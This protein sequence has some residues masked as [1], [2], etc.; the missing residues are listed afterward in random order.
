MRRIALRRLA[1]A[2]AISMAPLLSPLAAHAQAP[3]QKAQSPGW[4]RAMVG[5]IEVTALLDGTMKLDV[6]SL[7]TNVT[8]GQVNAALKQS[9]FGKEVETSVNAYLINTGKK[10]VLVD[11]GTGGVFGYPAL[12][13]D[14]LRA[15]GYK[16][17]Q[18]DEIYITH[19]HGDHLAGVATKEGAAAFPNAV[20]RIDKADTDYW[21]SQDVMNRAPKE[22]QDFFK[23]AMTAVKPYQATGKLKP[24]TGT[25]ELVPGVTAMPAH[26][27]TPGHTIYRVESKG[28]T[29]V[30]WGDL[31]HVA[32]VQ[33]PDPRV[34]IQFDSDSKAAMRE[35]Q[36]AFAE[37]AKKGWM[38]GVAHISFPGLGYIRPAAGGGYSWMPVNYSTL[39]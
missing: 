39:K 31:M 11:T 3:M 5:D 1:L 32:S 24:F 33:F 10:L 36:K 25:T 13:M 18:V 2:A 27:H 16:P 28:Q 4:Y 15:C 6:P 8:K 19:M 17:E 14:N 30:L 22:F 20:L 7:L 23:A 29:L 12:L 38:V 26:G 9:H 37:A 34:T 35:R 21:L